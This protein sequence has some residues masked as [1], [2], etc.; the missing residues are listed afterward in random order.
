M[1]S[2]FLVW[3][4][5]DWGLFFFTK[6]RVLIRDNVFADNVNSINGM[7]YDPHALSHKTSDKFVSIQDTVMIGRT[8]S[9]DCAI[10]AVEPVTAIV[11]EKQR[12]FRTPTGKLYCYFFLKCIGYFEIKTK[13]YSLNALKFFN[14]VLACN[15]YRIGFDI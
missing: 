2:G 11:N 6:S 12:A 13:F 7:V 15:F 4:I 5:Y 8:A 1:V 3:K 14:T 10:D 9:W